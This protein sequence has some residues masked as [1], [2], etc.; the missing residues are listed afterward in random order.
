M[1][2]FFR[3]YYIVF[4]ADC[5]ATYSQEDHDGTLRNIRRFFGEVVT[6]AEVTAC[7]DTSRVEARAV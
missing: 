1:T 2:F 3:D 5:T 4:T 7:W 6:A